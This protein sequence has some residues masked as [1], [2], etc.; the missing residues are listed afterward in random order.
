MASE[1]KNLDDSYL[2]IGRKVKT[3]E[4]G[5]HGEVPFTPIR[6]PKPPMTG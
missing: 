1:A 3:A 4:A 6:R 5:V 2:A